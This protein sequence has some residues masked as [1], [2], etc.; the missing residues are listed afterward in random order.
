ME[1]S[2][3]QVAA[4]RGR[5]RG[6][7]AAVP[8]SGNGDPL[9]GAGGGRV[10]G[11]GSAVPSGP[12]PGGAA[13][14]PSAGRR[15]RS[16]GGEAVQILGTSAELMS[17][18]KFEEIKKANQAAARKLVEE[19]CS[20]SEEE[21]D[22]DFEGKQGKIVA[23]T[24][25]SYTTHTDGDIHELERTKQ[26]VNEAFQAGAMTCLICIASVKRNQAVWS[27]SGCFCI[28]H[29]PCIQK[30]A[31]DSQFLVS[32]V[33]DEDFGKKDYPWPCPKCRFEYKRSETPS[34]YYCYCGKVEDP[35]LDPWL[36][37]HSCGQ[38]C[39][40]EFKPPCG[41]KCLLLC[42]PGEFHIVPAL[43]VQRWSQLLVTVRKQNLSLAGAVP[44]SG[45]A[46]CRVGASC[47]VG[48]ISVKI[49]VMQETVSLVQELVDRGVFV[50]KRKQKEVVRA[51]CGIVIRCVERHCH[52]VIIHVSKFVML[53][54]VES[55][56]APGRGPVHVRNQN[57]LC[58]VQKMSQLVE[59]AVTKC[60]NVGSIGVHSV[61]TEG[62][63]K[64]VDSVALETVYLV[65]KIVDGC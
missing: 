19:H 24:F 40:R 10:K 6:R 26:Y 15:Q 29:M 60:L 34:R 31:K 35:P 42:H 49:L 11:S 41:H 54:L 39:E 27:C 16:A 21:G 61:A 45:L 28:F 14:L 37:P 55:V 64:P 1:A 44:S 2:W 48:I 47:F 46:S 4:G 13:T 23:N 36:V 59:T 58:L 9:G 33:T 20:S 43:L 63:V 18:R 38:V 5:A 65:I 62:R 22:E 53:V 7:A 32:S 56:L 50:A 52:V 25:I 57:F 3:R 17:Q 8:S 51:Q 30:W 12:S